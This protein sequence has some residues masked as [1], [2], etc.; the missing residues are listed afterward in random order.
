MERYA[1]IIISEIDAGMYHVRLGNNTKPYRSKFWRYSFNSNNASSFDYMQTKKDIP[2]RLLKAYIPAFDYETFE[3]ERQQL[4]MAPCM[5]G[6]ER[7][8]SYSAVSTPRAAL[9]TH[10]DTSGV[11]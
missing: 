11:K 8:P 4:Y 1:R 5:H 6:V 7:N 10:L 9:F 3:K 2:K